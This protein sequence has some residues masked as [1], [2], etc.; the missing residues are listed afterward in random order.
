MS[1]AAVVISPLRVNLVSEIVL[2]NVLSTK[3]FSKAKISLGD[4]HLPVQKIKDISSPNCDVK[5]SVLT[6]IIN[7]QYRFSIYSQILSSSRKQQM[8]SQKKTSVH[9]ISSRSRSFFQLLQIVVFS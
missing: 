3:L 2:H 7:S 4:I 5:D 8:Q 1:S 9:Q 6:I